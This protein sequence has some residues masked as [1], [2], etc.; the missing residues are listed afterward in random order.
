VREREV[1]HVGSLH[2]SVADVEHGIEQPG[3]GWALSV[4][5]G[6]EEG[7]RCLVARVGFWRWSGALYPWRCAHGVPSTRTGMEKAW[8][9]VIGKDGWCCCILAV[10]QRFWRDAAV[11]GARKK[12]GKERSRPSASVRQNASRRPRVCAE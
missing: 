1:Q 4:Q 9:L 2:R 12:D 11:G 7:L 8:R 10:V 5:E 6:S 3:W